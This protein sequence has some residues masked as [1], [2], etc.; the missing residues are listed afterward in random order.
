MKR[1]APLLISLVALVALLASG[2]GGAEAHAAT[3]NGEQMSKSQLDDE[4]QAIRDNDAYVQAIQNNPQN[5]IDVIG[6]APRSLKSAFVAGVLTR[7]IIYELVLQ[8]VDD[9]GIEL[10]DEMV[11]QARKDIQQ[12]VDQTNPG[13]FDDFPDSYI[14]M[15]S[16]WFAAGTALENDLLE[17]DPAATDR[18]RAYFDAHADEFE[19]ACTSHILVE[20][21]QQAQEIRSQ[22]FTGADFA[23]LAKERSLDTGTAQ[24]GGELQCTFRGTLQPEYEEAAFS[25]PVGQV[26]EPVKTVFGWHLI[27][28]NRRNKPS[29]DEVAQQVQT[30]VQNRATEAFNQWLQKDITDAKVSVNPRF[31]KWDEVSGQVQPPGAPTTTTTPSE[32]PPGEEGPPPSAPPGGG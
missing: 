30:Q 15:I 12:Q 1:S 9:R 24:Q 19:Q 13:L 27:K 26:G 3:V 17:I 23:T 21:E 2:C 22:L 16:K 32:V 10:T 6:D 18:G 8:E 31:G 4:L 5:P 20:T 28:V 11:D 14:D 25:Q 29:Y 7:Q